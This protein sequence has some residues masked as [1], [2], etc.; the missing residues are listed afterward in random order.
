MANTATLG[1]R[2]SLLQPDASIIVAVDTAYVSQQQGVNISAGVSMMDNQVS[3]GSSGEGSM[4]LNTVVSNGSL[5]GFE[6]VPIDPSHGDTVIITGFNVSQ[7]SVFG[8]AGFPEVQPALANQ[9]AGS[10][11]IGQATQAGAQ[12]YQIQLLVTMGGLHP[13]QYVIN[14]D[15]YLTSN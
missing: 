7:G 2:Q 11:W 6:S 12:T 13:T 1:T 14:W 10:Y 3:N 8:S 5:I 15:P 9:P 4:E